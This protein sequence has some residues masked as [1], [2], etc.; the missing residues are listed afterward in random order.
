MVDFPKK[1]ITKDYGAIIDIVMIFSFIWTLIIWNVG[2]YLLDKEIAKPLSY[3]SKLLKGYK[4]DKVFEIEEFKSMPKELQ[5]IGS[6]FKYSS[7]L[8]E[9][10]YRDLK[11]FNENLESLVN[12]QTKEL[13]NKLSELKY[14][15]LELITARNE[16]LK[17]VEAKSI[18]ISGVSHELRTPL[19]AIINFTD[20][21]IEDFE[22]IVEDKQIREDSKNYL[23]RVL[24]NSK[25][26]LKLI[27]DILDFSKLEAGKIEYEDKLIEVNELLDILHQNTF[28]LKVGKNIEYILEKSK[29]RIYIKSDRRRVMQIALNLISNAIKFTEEGYVK[30]ST[31]VEKD[32]VHLVFEDSGRG[33]R[34]DKLDEIFV[35]FSQVNINDQGTGLGL[36]IVKRY[37]DDLG[38]DIEVKSKVGEGSKF[39]VKIKIFNKERVK[40]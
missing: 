16:A 20:M 14:K 29:E 24:H 6:S 4:P 38:F 34:E 40:T 3:I 37:C 31:K 30:V 8:L 33:I 9:S 28:S 7:L 19:N 21:V 1:N 11:I 26:L 23:A 25:Q 22:L 27:N 10:S 32:E 39:V 13:Q 15:N 36:G 18:F 35:P 5:E 12:N 17:A 2:Y